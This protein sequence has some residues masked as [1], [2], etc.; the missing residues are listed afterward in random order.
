MGRL[1]FWIILLSA[2]FDW[3]TYGLIYSLFSAMVFHRDFAFL[4]EET[5]DIIRGL[6]LGVILSVSPLAQFIS[7]PIAGTISDQKG[8]KCVLICLCCIVIFGTFLSFIAVIASTLSLFIISRIISGIGGAKIV[9]LNSGMADLSQP[10]IKA[11]N[12]TLITLAN[13][14]G[15]TIGPY[16]GGQLYNWKG[17]AAPFMGAILVSI[18]DLAILYFFFSETLLTKGSAKKILASFRNLSSIIRIPGLFALLISTLIFCIGW[19]FYWEFIPV[20]WIKKYQLFPQQIGNFY[21]YASTVYVLS[22]LA[23]RFV[24]SSF[25]LARILFFCLLALSASIAPL[26]NAQIGLFWIL[27]PLQ[28]FLLALMIPTAT[29]IISNSVTPT[30]QGSALGL[31]QSTQSMAF[32]ATPLIAGALVGWHVYMPLLVGSLLTFIAALIFGCGYRKRIF[33]RRTL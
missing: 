29:T 14:M 22:C 2:F 11:K 26:L 31:F 4:P 3:M 16:L 27:I 10:E 28:Q 13:A 33:G 19:S 20:T 6:W 15:F 32:A 23:A 24:V 5:P 18:V 7:S 9:L 21:A 17:Y 25:R 30:E 8:R 1:T 12:Y